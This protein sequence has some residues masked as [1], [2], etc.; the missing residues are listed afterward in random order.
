MLFV[1]GAPQ[2]V[3][4]LEH[5]VHVRQQLAALVGDL[6]AGPP[7]FEEVHAELVCEQGHRIPGRRD[8]VPRPGPGATPAS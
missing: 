8:V 4:G 3:H 7:A 5:A 6:G 1:R 2:P